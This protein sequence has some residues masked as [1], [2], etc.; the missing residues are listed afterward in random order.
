V[1]D[2]FSAGLDAAR[3]LHEAGRTKLIG[4]FPYGNFAHQE[5]SSGFLCGMDRNN[6]SWHDDSVLFFSLIRRKNPYQ[7]AHNQD[8]IFEVDFQRMIHAL[9]DADGVF[10]G[11]LITSLVLDILVQ[12]GKTPGKDVSVLSI[13]NSHFLDFTSIPVSALSHAK[14]KMGIAAAQ[15]MI[16]LLRGA[17]PEHI[18]LPFEFI[19][20][21][22]V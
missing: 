14:E 3:L 15:L 21:G 18:S 6:A 4:L 20:R 17:E 16:R 5:R 2:S 1:M 7:V 10:C 11:D 13:T 8:T 19:D 12:H 22:S 9:Q